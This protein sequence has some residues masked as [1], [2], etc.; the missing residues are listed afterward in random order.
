[1][2]LLRTFHHIPAQMIPSHSCANVRANVSWVDIPKMGRF[3][4]Y[5]ATWEIIPKHLGEMK[6]SYLFCHEIIIYS[7]EILILIYGI[8]VPKPECIVHGYQ[9]GPLSQPCII[10]ANGWISVRLSRNARQWC[11]LQPWPQGASKSWMS[12]RVV[13]QEWL[14]NLH[15]KRFFQEKQAQRLVMI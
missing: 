1:M 15:L 8:N 14:T 2:H 9:A 5:T 4:R 10:Q 3:P 12:S 7:H 6:L 13:S 11:P